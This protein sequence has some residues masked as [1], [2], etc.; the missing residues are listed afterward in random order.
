M[1][2]FNKALECHSK[3]NNFKG[4]SWA[5]FSMGLVYGTLNKFQDMVESTKKRLISVRK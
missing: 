5:Y 4:M 2:C 1:E 3:N